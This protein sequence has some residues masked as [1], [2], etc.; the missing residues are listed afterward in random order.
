MPG[1]G[2]KQ[3]RG[4]MAYELQQQWREWNFG[5]AE[6][7]AFFEHL[8]ALKLR[9]YHWFYSGPQNN[10]NLRQWDYPPPMLWRVCGWTLKT[11]WLANTSWLLQGE[12]PHTELG[13]PSFL[14]LLPSTPLFPLQCC[15]WRYTSQLVRVICKLSPQEIHFLTPVACLPQVL[16]S[17]LECL[18]M[19]CFCFRYPWMQ[20][21]S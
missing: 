15:Y 18:G 4:K 2:C 10:Y 12:W 14:L 5:L 8:P 21:A 9:M 1:N 7:L 6:H 20:N 3:L 19:M 16:C 11:W 17:N 13:F